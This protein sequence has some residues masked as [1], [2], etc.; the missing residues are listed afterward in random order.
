MSHGQKSKQRHRIDKGFHDNKEGIAIHETD[1]QASKGSLTSCMYRD[2]SPPEA[3]KTQTKDL[4]CLKISYSIHMEPNVQTQA[5]LPLSQMLLYQAYSSDA[6]EGSAGK[7]HKMACSVNQ[8]IN[9]MATTKPDLQ[10]PEKTVYPFHSF[11]CGSLLTSLLLLL[12]PKHGEFC[13]KT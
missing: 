7:Q 12:L 6:Q 1:T 11:V 9:L 4:Y 10:K 3:L 5:K 2:R 13:C 8:S